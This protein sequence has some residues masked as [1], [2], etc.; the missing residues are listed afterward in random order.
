MVN[1]LMGEWSVNEGTGVVSFAPYPE[2]IGHYPTAVEYTVKE[3]NGDESNRAVIEI[4]YIGFIHA[5]DDLNIP[6]K[7]YTPITI[8]VL[9]NGD[10]FGYNGPGTEPIYFTQ[11]EYGE[12]SLDDG[13]TPNDPTDDVLIYKP[14]A[15]I[16]N[17]VD[18]FTYTITEAEGHTDTAIV[19]VKVNCASSQTS[20]SGDALGTWSIMMMLLMTLISGLYFVKK[21]EKGNI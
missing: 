8:D 20:D 2:L 15:D 10:T 14:K 21:E 6:V 3:E 13:G 11:P 5:I 1:K 19:S 7:S 9:A 12:V 18:T 17:I 4:D 16:N